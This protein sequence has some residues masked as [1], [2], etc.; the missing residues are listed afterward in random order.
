MNYSTAKEVARDLTKLAL[1]GSPYWRVG[2]TVCVLVL[3]LSAGWGYLNYASADAVDDKNT[4]AIEPLKA[5]VDS[6]KKRQAKDAI[7]DVTA[8]ILNAKRDQ[9]DATREGRN[10]RAW[11][12]RLQE[13]MDDYYSLSGKPFA[14]PTC[15]EV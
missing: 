14:M 15:Q 12:E 7:N 8:S 2:V 6:I 10:A 1:N 3:G 13:L 4:K 9:C 11:T 5:D